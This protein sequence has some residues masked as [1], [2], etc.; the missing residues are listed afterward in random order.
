MIFLDVDMISLDIIL[1]CGESS[2][3]NSSS[4]ADYSGVLFAQYFRS[5]LT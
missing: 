3:A 2:I 1:L 5:S 4:V